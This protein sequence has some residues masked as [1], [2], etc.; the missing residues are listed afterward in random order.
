[1]TSFTIETGEIKFTEEDTFEN[2]ISQ[3]QKQISDKILCIINGTSLIFYNKKGPYPKNIRYDYK[4]KRN[5]ISEY[6]FRDISDDNLYCIF[7]RENAILLY[8]QIDISDPDGSNEIQKKSSKR[9]NEITIVDK[10]VKMSF[11]NVDYPVEV[12]TYEINQ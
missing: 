7:G 4:Q 10:G 9:L 3:F 12:K 1:M 2:F 8:P 5:G 11:E 6:Y